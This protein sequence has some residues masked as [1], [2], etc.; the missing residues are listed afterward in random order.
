MS[1]DPVGEYSKRVFIGTHG[2]FTR[3][4]ATLENPTRKAIVYLLAMRGPL[5]LKELSEELNLAPSTVH[6]HLR[7]LKEIGF[8][9]EASEHPKKFKVEIYYRLTLPYILFS[10][11]SSLRERLSTQID[12]LKKH[13]ADLIDEIGGILAE[14]SELKCL[15]TVPEHLRKKVLRNLSLALVVQASV[16][17]LRE[18]A[19]E[20][21]VYALINDLED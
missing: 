1:G 2:L 10:E 21:F 17:I 15:E 3:E 7:R 5:T 16:I 6:E 9:E 13:V 12:V 14:R 4:L 20:S 19:G 11:L 18:L 8:I